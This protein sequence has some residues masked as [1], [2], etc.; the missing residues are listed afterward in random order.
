MNHSEITADGIYCAPL[1]CEIKLP[2]PDERARFTEFMVRTREGGSL[3]TLT[4]T[5]LRIAR[6]TVRPGGSL[7]WW[8]PE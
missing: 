4:V 1:R 3:G 8:F 7:A 6:F 2:T 5:A